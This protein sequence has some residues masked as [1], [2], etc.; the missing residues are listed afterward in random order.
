MGFK[1]TENFRVLFLN[2]KNLLADELFDHGTID[3]IAIYPREIVKKA[4]FYNAAAVIL[5]HNHPSGDPSP[6]E[7]GYCNYKNNNVSTDAR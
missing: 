5:V 4:V 2:K 3:K 6:S 1:Q 7:E